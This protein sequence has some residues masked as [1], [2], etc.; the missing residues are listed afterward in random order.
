MFSRISSPAVFVLALAWLG[1][2][3]A[4]A[5]TAP[6]VDV[7]S[8]SLTLDGTLRSVLDANPAITSLDEL[9]NA[10][11]GRLAQTR[12]GFLP[13]VTGTATYTRID[14]VV[15]LPFGGETLHWR[16]T[17]TT[18]HTSRRSTCCWTLAKATRR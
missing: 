2:G 14:P 7:I 12:T 13:Q 4:S 16:P 1:G 3:A 8:D 5:Q 6:G 11:S 9:A 17:T 10:A 18:T 15:K